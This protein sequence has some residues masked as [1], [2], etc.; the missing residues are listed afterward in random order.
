MAQVTVFLPANRRSKLSSQ[1]LDP[2]PAQPSPALNP[3]GIWKGNQQ[4]FNS[5]PSFYL[6]KY[7]GKVRQKLSV[8][9]IYTIFQICNFG[10]RVTALTG[11]F[12]F[13]SYAMSH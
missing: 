5:F 12:E 2:A 13:L 6:S 9:P 1:L 11:P 4:R 8:G 3:V 10:K 7:N